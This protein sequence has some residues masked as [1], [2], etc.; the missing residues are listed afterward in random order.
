MASL[1]RTE[2]AVARSLAQTAEPQDALAGALRAIG[3][4][5]GWRLGAVWEPAPDRPEAL[6]CVETWHADGT[7]AEE[8]E[9]AS[10]EA[11]LAAGEGLPGRVWRSGEPAWVADV[12]A[13]DNFP[14]AP[15]ARRAG[16]RAAFCFPIRSARGVLGVIEFFTAEPREPDPELLGTM[17]A[18][19]DQIGQAVERRRDTEALRAKEAR[20]RAMLDAALD[21]VVTMDHRGCVVDFNPAAE[22]TFGYSAGDAVGRDMA[23]LIIPPELR[24]RHRRGLA[25]YV[26]TE[27][28][29]VLD[30]RLEITGLRADG[31]TFPVELTITRIDV[32]GPPIFTGYI[33]DITDRKAGEAE[34][35]ASRARIVKAA[36]EARR[37]LER[38]L[39]DGAQQRLVELA[40][41]LRMARARLDDEPAQA[42]ELLDAALRD[43][44]EATRELRELA[45]GIHPA[46]LTEGGLRPALEALTAR[47]RIPARLVVV[48]DGRFPAMVEATAY[49]SVA[50]GLTNAARH[51][52][53]AH[54]EVEVVRVG[55][56][57]RVVVRDDGR[58]GAER[59][60]GSGLRGL[61]DRVAALDGEVEVV[62]PES[63]GTVLRVEVPCGS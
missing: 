4:S 46:A 20:H 54:V 8:F 17:S 63:G 35:R 9:A 12:T 13:D 58:G 5:L 50:E 45:R 43:L 40:L 49:F 47:S 18:L 41:D 52:A 32:P 62:S 14:R 16:L 39:H 22:R 59:G 44:E 6:T 30:R 28:A 7:A 27:R 25:H 60:A 42:Q 37:Q 24:E 31:T 38:D 23:E 51:A 10:R 48:P 55:D 19:G 53:A 1:P 57:L 36:D 26:A 3:E 11:T 29:I 56:R 61:A 34:L 2:Q 15:A 21:C 33:R